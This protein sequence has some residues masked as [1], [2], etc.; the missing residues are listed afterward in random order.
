M[1]GLLAQPAGAAFRSLVNVQQVRNNRWHLLQ[2][3]CLNTFHTRQSNHC[4]RK[5]CVL[6]HVC[7][8]S[9]L[10]LPCSC[11]MFKLGPTTTLL[12]DTI[13]QGFTMD[14]GTVAAKLAA[15]PT[16]ASSAPPGMTGGRPLCY[17]EGIHTQGQQVTYDV[18]VLLV[19]HT[20]SHDDMCLPACINLP[21]YSEEQSAGCSLHLLG[22]CSGSCHA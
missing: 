2:R 14:L 7:S 17:V 13:M 12:N 10:S 6:G 20:L 22:K 3:A 11:L 4:S 15:T 19:L 5:H 16:P 21:T 9:L 18:A 8:V 1:D